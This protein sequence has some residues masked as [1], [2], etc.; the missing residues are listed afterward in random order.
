ML[1]IKV[2]TLGDTFHNNN[3]S[4]HSDLYRDGWG[5]QSCYSVVIILKSKK[6]CLSTGSQ[7]FTTWC[8]HLVTFSFQ[9][10]PDNMQDLDAH[11]TFGSEGVGLESCP[12]CSGQSFHT[13]PKPSFLYLSS[14]S[15][16]AGAMW[17]QRARYKCISWSCPQS[18][19]FKNLGTRWEQY[20]EM[21]YPMLLSFHGQLH[22]SFSCRCCSLTAWLQDRVFFRGYIVFLV[23]IAIHQV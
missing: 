16:G 15:Q 18:P 1:R 11:L 19:Y 20:F 6:T 4:K 17:G 9:I 7:A 23:L 3:I 13:L 2:I 5:W 21:W 8:L 14:P 22:S 12:N 10:Q